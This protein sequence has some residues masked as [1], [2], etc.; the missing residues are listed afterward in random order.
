MEGKKEEKAY[1][2]LTSL[3]SGEGENTL[4]FL[5]FKIENFLYYIG[6]A[7][8]IIFLLLAGYQFF[9]GESESSKKNVEDAQKSLTYALVAFAILLLL[10]S[11]FQIIAGIFGYT[12]D[13]SKI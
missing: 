9:F 3:S 7:V 6:I 1:E 13:P 2:I 12:L 11:I 8:C 4:S 10:R 5:L